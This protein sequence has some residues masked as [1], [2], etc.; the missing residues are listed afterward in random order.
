MKK[1][2]LA[3]TLLL[4]FV[5]SALGEGHVPIMG[6]TGCQGGAWYPDSQVC[7]LPNQECPVGRSASATSNDTKDYILSGLIT[8]FKD[9]WF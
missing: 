8:M 7:C 1:I 2:I 5:F 6:Y 3:T 4:I 9:I